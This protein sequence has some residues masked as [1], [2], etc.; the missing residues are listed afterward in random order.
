MKNFGIYL[1]YAPGVDLRHEGLGRYLAAFL[2][3]AAD[4]EDIKFTIICPSWSRAGLL[5]LFQSEKVPENKFEIVAPRGK[6]WLL[7]GFEIVSNFKN[8]GKKKKKS[9]NKIHLVFSWIAGVRSEIEKKIVQCHGFDG[10]VKLPFLF[11]VWLVFVLLLLPYFSFLTL[12]LLFSNAFLKG[13]RNFNFLER[14]INGLK[15]ILKNPKN[16]SFVFQLYL[17]L[18]EMEVARLLRIVSGLKHVRAWYCP[19]AF[20]PAF[21]KI[22][23]PRLMCVPD[24]VLSEF[25]VGFSNVGGDRFLNVFE[26]VS[27][28]IIEGENF[29]TYS[30]HVKWSTVVDRYGIN[31]KNVSVIHH[32]PNR[33]NGILPERKNNRGVILEAARRIGEGGYEKEMQNEELKFIFYASQFR[34]NKNV[35]TLLRAYFYLKERYFISH[36]LIMTGNLNYPE[37]GQIKKYIYEHNLQNDILCFHGLKLTELAAF[38]SYAEIAV[39]PS[40]SEGGCPFTFTEALSVDTPVVMARISVTEE[41]LTDPELQEMTF[42]DP[43]DWRDLAGRIAWALSNREKLLDVQRKTYAELAKRTWTDV[44]NEHIAVLERISNTEERAIQ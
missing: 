40:L 3:G 30:N 39:N 26:T 22:A 32:A 17:H 28:S 5:D 43:Y 6:P 8:R 37:N 10:L 38:Y 15:F 41:V 14:L 24:V 27:Q 35:I 12:F 31:S 7:L 13:C 44:V 29:V 25:A 4:R 2:K 34:P 33:L 1:C 36:K 42:F 19:T 9:K 21:N 18:E 23:A 11:V 20:W 16:S